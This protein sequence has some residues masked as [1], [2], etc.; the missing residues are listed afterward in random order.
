VELEREP[1]IGD[2]WALVHFMADVLA[3]AERA[4]PTANVH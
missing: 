2:K 4:P 1:T 3:E